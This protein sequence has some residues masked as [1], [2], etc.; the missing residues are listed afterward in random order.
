[1]N[2]AS[3]FSES[4]I[5]AGDFN[6]GPDL[7]ESIRMTSGYYDNWQRAMNAGIAAITKPSSA[8]PENASNSPP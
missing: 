5:V 8:Q 3:T 7:S 4:R 2:F 1:M 6:A